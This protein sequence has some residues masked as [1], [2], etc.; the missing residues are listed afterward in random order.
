M[1]VSVTAWSAHFLLPNWIKAQ[2]IFWDTFL[3]SILSISPYLWKIV[4]ISL[5]LGNY[6]MSV[7]LTKIIVPG[8]LKCLGKILSWVMSDSSAI[9]LLYDIIVVVL[10]IFSLSDQLIDR[11]LPF[12]CS[13][14]N[15]EKDTIFSAPSTSSNSTN[16]WDWFLY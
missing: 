3:I 13:V 6:L 2:N 15:L 8:L 9:F 14:V 7:I 5:R 1:F 12:S 4:Y 16:A 11:G 10:V